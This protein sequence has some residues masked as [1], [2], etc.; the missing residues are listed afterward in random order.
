MRV[1]HLN[2]HHLQYF[3]S[4]AREG[5][6]TRAARQLRIAPSALS[7]QIRQLEEQIGEPLFLR[8]GRTLALSEA[9][10]IALDYADLIFSAGGELVAT[11]GKGR[12]REQTL[13]IGA[14]ATLS[15]NF[16]DSFLSP[17]L[18]DPA[19]KL[20]LVSGALDPL[21][22]RLESHSLDV[23]L[24]NRPVRR[25]ERRSLKC[26][27]MARQSVSLVSH[28]SRKS[29]RFPRDI[30]QVPLL[31]PGPESDVR[32]T[33]DAMCEKLGVE[34][35][36]V[37]EVDDMAMMRL[38]ARDAEVV[39]LLPPVVVRDELRTG[40][41][42]ECC[43]VPDLFEEFYAITADRRYPHPLLKPLLAQTVDAL[44]A[45]AP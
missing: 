30:G 39:A 11:L 19:T 27:H 3:W 33:F 37:A 36:V 20:R 28:P 21:L 7:A 5:N 10:R 22:D 1:E 44:L 31:L 24:A 15:R 4:V 23:V 2:Y 38:L 32:A 34:T 12:K 40:V 42:R 17:L 8:E 25:G 35:N 9:G 14:V 41:L 45:P 16:Q 13:S 26:R 29:F 6:L 43:V 18:G